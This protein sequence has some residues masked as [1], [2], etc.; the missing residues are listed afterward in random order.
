MHLKKSHA[1]GD[2]LPFPQL[3][4]A[5]STCQYRCEDVVHSTTECIT[6]FFLYWNTHFQKKKKEIFSVQLKSKTFRCALTTFDIR[7]TSPGSRLLE[8]LYEYKL[9]IWLSI[10]TAHHFVVLTAGMVIVMVISFR[11]SGNVGGKCYY[12]RYMEMQVNSSSRTWEGFFWV[13]YIVFLGISFSFRLEMNPK[14]LSYIY[15]WDKVR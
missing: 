6:T 8:M 1:S 15:R 5:H 9:V 13:T 3:I 7:I 2:S 10:W 12:T 14:N 11:G 4:S